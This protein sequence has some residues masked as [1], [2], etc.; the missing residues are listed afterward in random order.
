[1]E[2]L[3][4]G[5]NWQKKKKKKVLPEELSNAELMSVISIPT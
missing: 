4:S 2:M 5:G 1:M 3:Y